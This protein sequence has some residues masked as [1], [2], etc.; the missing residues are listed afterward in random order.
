MAVIAMGRRIMIWAGF[1]AEE[2]RGGQARPQGSTVLTCFNAVID[3]QEGLPGPWMIAI[4][5]TRSTGLL[6]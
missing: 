2:L 5:E 4:R 1:D 6:R 3:Q